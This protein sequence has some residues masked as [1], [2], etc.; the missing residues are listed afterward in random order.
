MKAAIDSGS[1]QQR[2]AGTVGNDSKQV[3][4][5]V[6]LLSD[7]ACISTILADTKYYPAWFGSACLKPEHNAC[8]TR[9]IG[10]N[11]RKQQQWTYWDMPEVSEP[12]RLQDPTSLPNLKPLKATSRCWDSMQESFPF[13]DASWSSAKDRLEGWGSSELAQ[14]VCG[15]LVGAKQ[16]KSSTN[17]C[18]S[19]VTMIATASIIATIKTMNL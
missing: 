14:P 11:T 18:F 13:F 2:W 16:C 12:Y 6:V 9:L 15:I 7:C 5:D 17:Y 8:F 4:M 3:T 10:T 19:S 1:R